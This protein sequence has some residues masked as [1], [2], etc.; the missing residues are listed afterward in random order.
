MPSNYIHYNASD[1]SYTFSLINKPV[2]TG[3][4]TSIILGDTTNKIYADGNSQ[5][6]ITSNLDVEQSLKVTT[7]LTA[8]GQLSVGYTTN[9]SPNYNLLAK[10]NK[11]AINKSDINPNY[12][13]DVGG[14]TKVDNDLYVG[15]SS[16]FV[17]TTNI[18]GSFNIATDKFQ[19]ISS[20]GNTSIA[21][22]LTVSGDLTANGNTF[23]GNQTTDT[24]TVSGDL[25]VNGALLGRVPLGSIIPLVTGYFINPSGGVNTGNTGTFT[26]VS[27][28]VP[29]SGTIT[30]DGFL[31]CNGALIPTTANSLL[32]SISGGQQRYT[33]DLTD[34]RFLQ[35]STSSGTIST[36][37]GV[38][39]GDNT[40]TLTINN[41]PSHNHSSSVSSANANIS[42]S[43]GS[44]T[45]VTD[46]IIN[47]AVDPIPSGY[48]II[49]GGN[50]ADKTP[51]IGTAG[52]PIY[53]QKTSYSTSLSQTSHS[54]TI[55]SEGG[56]QSFDIRPRYM[57]VIYVMRV[58]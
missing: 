23:L 3:K 14:H 56:G 21:G 54:H 34:N 33:P 51:R 20:N 50:A 53:Q 5:L 43:G 27:G 52:F 31:Y 19:V 28:L 17:G 55:T 45:P 29:T 57:N 22:T 58:K 30:N 47:N 32:A 18:T 15:G 11:V 42:F 49:T 36:D 48:Q 24:T 44:I 7:D 10:T 39:N 16:T 1:T 38:N 12:T 46:I 37:T 2:G 40:V 8:G 35:G 9:P 25:V 6:N 4:Q 41:L 26:N 13:L